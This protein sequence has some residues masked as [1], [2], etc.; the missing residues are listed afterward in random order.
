[1]AFDSAASNLVPGDTNQCQMDTDPALDPC[2]DVFLRDLGDSDN[3]LVLD[4]FDN[5]TTTANVGQT[6]SDGDS[7]GD[8]CD[9]CPSLSNPAQTNT[10]GDSEGDACDPD[11]DNDAVLDAADVCAATQSGHA[12]D[13]VG[14]SD[15]QVD[16]DA[17]GL[18][19]PS[20][21]SPG[22]SGCSGTDNCP[23]VANADGQ[24][25]DIDG[26]IAGDA[27]DGPGSGNVDCSGPT[28]VNS[29][30]ALKL[31]RFSA[32]LPVVQSE[33]CLDIGLPRALPP[34]DDWKMGDVDCSGTVNSIDA[35][36]IL[37]ANAGLSVA[38][39]AGCLEVRP[40]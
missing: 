23:A 18:C 14:C 31:L 16:L 33:P 29:I 9:N 12:V 3:D 37:R 1:V 8:A 7:F 15:A 17:D 10:D 2:A 6:D 21:P 34:P 24:G 39:P 38:I 11:D 13:G 19:S 25:A 30:D 27:C 20:A 26:D 28:G 32:S 4:P 22:P 40:P 36:K 35:L 5:C